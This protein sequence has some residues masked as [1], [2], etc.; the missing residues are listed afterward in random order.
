MSCRKVRSAAFALRTIAASY[1]CRGLGAPIEPPQQV[2][3]DGVEQ[4]VRLEVE[5]VDER[6]RGLRPFHFGHRDRA[7]ELPRSGSAR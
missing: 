3:A 6:E 2:G 1:A 7:I 5:R 4:V